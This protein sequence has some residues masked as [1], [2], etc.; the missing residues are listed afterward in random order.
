MGKTFETREETY[1]FYDWMKEPRVKSYLDKIE[2][3][4]ICESIRSNG[5]SGNS[6]CL[7]ANE[8]FPS[9]HCNTCLRNIQEHEGLVKGQI[10]FI[11]NKRVII[12][13]F[14]PLE[15]CK[16]VWVKGIDNEY[17]CEWMTSKEVKEILDSKSNKILLKE[18]LN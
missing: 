3:D 1:E 4:L 5:T 7:Y 14:C 18:M 8:G 17:F 6:V 11:D 10:F 12:D 9:C 15:N 16:D 13:H 2:F